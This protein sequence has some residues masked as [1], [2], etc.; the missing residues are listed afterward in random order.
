MGPGGFGAPG[1][2]GANSEAAKELSPNGLVRRRYVHRTD[3]VRSMPIGIMLIC[4]QTYSADVLTVLANSKLRMQIVQSHLSRFRGTI[5]YFGEPGGS[6]SSTP[7]FPMPPGG[8]GFPPMGSGNPGFPMP[9]ANPGRME[10]GNPGFPS[11]LGAPRSSSEDMVAGN[12][13][14]LSVYGIA[15][16]Y[17]KFEL[18]DA[19]KDEAKKDEAKKDDT[20]M[21]MPMTPAPMNNVP[22]P[23]NNVP[24]PMNNV[25]APMNNVPAPM[26]PPAVPMPATPAPTDNP[27]AVP[28]M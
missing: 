2:S 15:S 28:K 8:V 4:D 12:L 14:E 19:K 21:P 25:P 26:N 1:G 20:P 22:A 18:P 7:G 23:M 5:S 27:P 3:Q 11:S 17:E 10:G 6:S 16:L 24:A 9:P 13:I